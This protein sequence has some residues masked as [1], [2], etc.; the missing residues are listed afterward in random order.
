MLSV[1]VSL[2]Q[3]SGSRTGTGSN[4]S[5]FLAT[6]DRASHCSGDTSDESAFCSAM[7]MS[8][9]APPLG[10]AIT[11]ENSEQQ[12]QPHDGGHDALI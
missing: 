2:N 5:P 11:D 8:S 10:K 1:S 7:V 9:I 3:V 12:D 6:D 4:Q